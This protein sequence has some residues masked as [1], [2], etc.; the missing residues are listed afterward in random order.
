MNKRKIYLFT[1]SFPSK[2][3]E[4]Y[5]T[6]EMNAISNLGYDIIYCPYAITTDN[7]QA[8]NKGF[9]PKK[10]DR[11]TALKYILGDFFVAPLALTVRKFRYNLA[12]V[13]ERI[14]A[15]RYYAKHIE[16][17]SV[18]YT[19][20]F[21]ELAI[22]AGFI[23]QM[24]PD[25]KWVS[26]GH[27]FDIYEEQSDDNFLFFKQNKLALID[28]LFTV[29]KNGASYM[30]NQHPRYSD[31]MNTSY[32]GTSKFGALN[33]N[34][35]LNKLVIVT[36]AY[37]RSIKRLDLI[38]E[39]LPLVTGYEIEWHIIGDGPDKAKLESAT[40]ML[41]NNINCIFYGDCNKEQISEIYT[42]PIDCFINVS[43]SEGLPVSIMEAISAGIPI[44]A[45]DVGGTS[46]IVNDSTG[47]LIEKDFE[48]LDLANAIAV[49]I[50]K[51]KNE[52][53]RKNI[54]IYWEENF[55]ALS[56][57]KHFYKEIIA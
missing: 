19:Y 6:D 12:L 36:C 27:G 54:S 11:V 2:G 40:T 9:I 16:I 38:M 55:N 28:T 37:I 41:P 57:Y 18:I 26:R 20:W 8:L 48:V 56:N 23:K 46:E 22:T 3:G 13:K 43:V 31:K 49:N 24:R 15:A 25:L 42:L 1:H 47:V 14:A 32:L 30:K 33:R 17:G 7:K 44:I 29:S 51:F 10:K 4:V 50:A 21:D 39:A 35:E 5:L 52:E 45:T 34:T 53:Y